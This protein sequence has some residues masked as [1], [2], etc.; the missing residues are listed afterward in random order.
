MVLSL[1]WCELEGM[2]VPETGAP[3][4]SRKPEMAVLYLLQI[5]PH[6]LV[7]QRSTPVSQDLPLTVYI[8][9][10]VELSPAARAGLI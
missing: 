5:E 3:V 8:D 1:L 9:D 6:T 10:I 7:P 4:I 2:P